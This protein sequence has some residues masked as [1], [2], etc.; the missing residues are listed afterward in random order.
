MESSG[1]S[2]WELLSVVDNQQRGS[3]LKPG[4]SRLQNVDI[5]DKVRS[6]VV[7]PWCTCG[8][9]ITVV[10]SFCLSVSLLISISLHAINEVQLLYEQMYILR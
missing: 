4:R 10:G 6:T 1:Q 2:Q 7:N 8:A 3:H 5:V 9:K